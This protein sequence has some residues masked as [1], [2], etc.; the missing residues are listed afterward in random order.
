MAKASLLLFLV[1]TYSGNTR[2]IF[3]RLESESLQ[4]I[5]CAARFC[6]RNKRLKSSRK[7]ISTVIA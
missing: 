7:L 5:A 1:L 6:Y 4:K 3:D 2:R